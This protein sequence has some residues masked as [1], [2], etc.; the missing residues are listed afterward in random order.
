MVQKY[1]VI[2]GCKTFTLNGLVIRFTGKTSY[3]LEYL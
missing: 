1:T 3:E 2:H